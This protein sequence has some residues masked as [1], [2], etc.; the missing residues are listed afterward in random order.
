MASILDRMD[1]RYFEVTLVKW[2]TLGVNHFGTYRM[3]SQVED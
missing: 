3:W 2:L 1:G